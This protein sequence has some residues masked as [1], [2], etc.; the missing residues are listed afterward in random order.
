M[1]ACCWHSRYLTSPELPAAVTWTSRGFIHSRPAAG[2]TRT[3]Q[4]ALQAS[5]AQQAGG[6]PAVIDLI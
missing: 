6:Q 4:A 2:A 5:R 3:D 1:P